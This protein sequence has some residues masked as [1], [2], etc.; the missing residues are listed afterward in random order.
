VGE[1]GNLG[2][3]HRARIEA[4]SRGIGVSADFI[5]NA[6]GVDSSDHEVNLKILLG[7]AVAR[8]DITVDERNDILRAATD[9]V[10]A[11]VLQ[12][13]YRQARIL[14]R[15]V[16][17]S[18]GRIYAYEDLMTA[19]E[20]EGILDRDADALPTVA[21]LGQR[22]RGGQGLHRPELAVLLAHSKRSLTAAL[23]DSD[24]VE[25]PWFARDLRAYFPPAI[26]ERF[27]DL[28]AEHRLRRELLATIVANEVVDSL[29][30]SFISR[31]STELG[32]APAAVV[33]AYR[34]ARDVTGAIGR[35]A[36][37]D[38]LDTELD[39]E[40]EVELIDGVERLV[41]AVTRWYLQ[42]AP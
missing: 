34:I 3:T 1:G 38:A 11:H 20:E 5:D 25:D 41:E 35:F 10:V 22:R 21:Q 31:L 18:A 13:C 24:L 15:E 32:A 19:L 7:M 37:I 36:T 23:L 30:P 29:G 40:A 4:A 17:T 39:D 6:A 8:G 42:H 12:N 33:R 27:G 9:Y 16:N 2:W 28:L 26:V 14:S